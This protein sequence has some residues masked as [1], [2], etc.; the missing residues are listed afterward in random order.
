ME[1]PAVNLK[2]ILL[3]HWLLAIWGCIVFPG[4]YAWSNFTILALG[5][6]A[7]A[8]RDSIDAIS[9]LSLDLHRITVPTRRLTLQK[10]L[11]TW[12]A[13]LMSR[14]DTEAS[15]AAP[16]PSLG[17]SLTNCGEGW[18]EAASPPWCLGCHP[19]GA[20]VP[21]PFSELMWDVPS[22]SPSQGLPESSVLRGQ[23]PLCT[24]VPNS[25]R[26]LFPPR[27][28]TGARLGTVVAFVTPTLSCSVQAL[29]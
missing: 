12:R 25:S 19:R 6:W 2:A 18:E 15:P 7:V 26:P 29:G 23:E 14:K 16:G 3:V 20:P 8:Q 11:P 9:M 5:V 13:G 1:L 24:P 21:P 4:A 22:G 28:P 10:P 17:A 27:H